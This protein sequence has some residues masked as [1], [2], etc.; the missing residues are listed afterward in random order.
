MAVTLSLTKEFLTEALLARKTPQYAHEPK[1]KG[2]S[3]DQEIFPQARIQFKDLYPVNQYSNEEFLEKFNKDFNNKDTQLFAVIG[4]A[5]A[6]KLFSGKS[7]EEIAQEQVPYAESAQTAQ[8]APAGEPAGTMSG[9]GMPFPGIAGGAAVTARR[10]RI[11]RIVP[12]AEEPKTTLYVANKSGNIIQERTITPSSVKVE[13]PPPAKLAVAD[14]SGN[15]VQERTITPTSVKIE[16]PETPSRLVIADKSGNTVGEKSLT[17]EKIKLPESKIYI[18]NKRGAVVGEHAIPKAPRFRLPAGM[19]SFGK[20][21]ASRAGIFLKTN[22]LPI[23][24]TGLGAFAGG[25][26]TGGNPLGM[27]SGG[28]G[29]ATWN[30]WGKK[31]LNGTIDAGARLS[32]VVGRGGLGGFGKGFGTGKKAALAFGLFGFLFLGVLITGILQGGG[33]TTP[34][35]NANPVS[36]G[37][38]LDYTL[39][40]KDPTITPVD[41]R[42]DIKAAFPGAKLEYWDTIIQQAR[43][44]GLNPAVALALWVEETGASQA[45]LIKNG[46]SEI[47]THG[48]LSKGHLGCAPGEDQTI[49]ESLTCLINFINRNN[50]TSDQFAQFMAKYSSG[51]PENPFAN[52][53]DFPKNFKIWYSKL[54]PAGPGATVA[55]TPTGPS[56]TAPASCPVPGGIISC[57]SSRGIPGVV[58]A[59]HCTSSYSPTCPAESRRGKA[60]DIKSPGGSKDGD[61]VYLPTIKGQ[62]LKWYFRQDYDDGEGA[63]LRVFQSGSTIDGVWTIQF[64]HSKRKNPG[65]GS[66]AAIPDFT[67]GQEITDLTKPVAFMD[68]SS[69]SEGV[70]IHTHVSIGL[71]GNDWGSGN[72]QYLNPG[73]KY[74]DA[75]MSMCVGARAP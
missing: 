5:S 4:K 46:G 24:R 25:V 56:L 64:V 53:P 27:L 8:Q 44:A 17:G 1:F 13:K 26:L 66:V 19:K 54:V 9:G 59:C 31:A 42:S 61:P 74:P 20:T 7:A 62:A 23:A 57:G 52:N 33:S 21:L 34:I 65:T 45:T 69:G 67:G 11:I 10:P 63:T 36:G 43:A 60:I 75:E 51:P 16:K 30:A 15:I 3:Y 38:G 22:M 35:A 32:N 72:I 48:N 28:V 39:P 47:L 29:G 50:F 49:D 68:K 2:R 18:A 40:L 71:I 73:W 41:I 55:V 37:G 58:A 12:H 70:G 6:E 14:K